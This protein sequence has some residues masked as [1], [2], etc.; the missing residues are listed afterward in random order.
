LNAIEE[1][2]SMSETSLL[3]PEVK[4]LIGQPMWAPETVLV[5]ESDILRYHEAL[6]DPMI[7]RG[8]DGVLI[9]PPLFLPP[10]HHGGTIAQ[11]GRRHKPEELEID[12]PVTKRLM[13]G[14]DITFGPAIRAGDTIT[15][16]VT[17]TNLTEKQGSTGPMLLIETEA[18]Y[19]NQDGA[20]N[21]TETW[22]VIR[23]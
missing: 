3:T 21:R 15:A 11:D 10:F 23:R 17:I 13:A 4:K 19:T 22:A 9:A 16:T 6:G 1:N 7:V 18:R 2:A 14:C 8:D 5:R 12:V 20:V